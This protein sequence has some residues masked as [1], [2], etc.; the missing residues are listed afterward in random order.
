MLLG[1]VGGAVT[2]YFSF[3]QS[4]TDARSVALSAPL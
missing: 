1:G 4:L 2:R 3:S